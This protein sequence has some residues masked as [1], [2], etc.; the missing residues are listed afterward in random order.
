MV[1]LLRALYG[2]CGSSRSVSQYAHYGKL[3]GILLAL[4][5]EYAEGVISLT[6]YQLLLTD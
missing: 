4:I 3:E 5:R 2:V 1:A 6:I